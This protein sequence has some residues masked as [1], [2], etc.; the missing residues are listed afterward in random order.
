MGRGARTDGVFVAWHGGR[1]D[2]LCGA[3]GMVESGCEC[4]LPMLFSDYADG[5]GML[6][7]DC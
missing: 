1:S 6:M 2:A 3:A 7:D 4:M 5:D